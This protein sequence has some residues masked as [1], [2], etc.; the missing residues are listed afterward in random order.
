M[1][2][3][4]IQSLR[5]AKKHETPAADYLTE[6]RSAEEQACYVSNWVGMGAADQTPVLPNSYC[7]KTASAFANTEADS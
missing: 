4:L 5:E 6:V 3:E 7:T 2:D 1:I